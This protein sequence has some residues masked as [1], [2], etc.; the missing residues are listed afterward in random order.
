[1]SGVLHSYLMKTIAQ[2]F[3]Q[4]SL[5]CSFN[6]VVTSYPLKKF[7]QRKNVSV[8]SGANCNINWFCQSFPHIVVVNSIGCCILFYTHVGPCCPAGLTKI[9]IG[10]VYHIPIEWLLTQLAAAFWSNG[11]LKKVFSIGI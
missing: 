7:H 10:S 1:M 3:N 8:F 5:N 6:S 2:G 11:S 9:S 4:N